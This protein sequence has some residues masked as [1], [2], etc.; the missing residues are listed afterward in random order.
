MIAF[1]SLFGFVR[2]GLVFGS[3]Y[4]LILLI[5]SRYQLIR[6]HKS[7]TC[8]F[9]AA[10]NANHCPRKADQCTNKSRREHMHLQLSASSNSVLILIATWDRGRGGLLVAGSVHTHSMSLRLCYTH[11]CNSKTLN[12]KI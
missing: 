3:I 10:S 5:R 2:I 6:H 9:Q 8:I 7:A 12:W 11:F 1:F 4:Y